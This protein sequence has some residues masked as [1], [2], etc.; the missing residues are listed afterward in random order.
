MN[1]AAI[2]RREATNLANNSTF[3]AGYHFVTTLDFLQHQPIGGASLF[4][5]SNCSDNQ[6]LSFGESLPI[7]GQKLWKQI[8]SAIILTDQHR[9]NTS[10]PGGKAL[11]DL[12]QI[13]WSTDE[14]WATD[15]AWAR[16]TA[17]SM[18]D[19]INSRVVKASEMPAFMARGPRA[20][21][22]RNEIKPAL[23]LELAKNHARITN[24][25]LFLWRSVDVEAGTQR[26]LSKAV[27]STL[28]RQQPENTADMPTYMAFFDGCY[29]VFEDSKFPDL[30]WVNNLC[31]VGKKICLD[32]RE[33]PDDMSQPYRLLHYPPVSI[34]VR[35]DGTTLGKLLDNVPEHCLPVSRR[36]KTFTVRAKP[37]SIPTHPSCQ[38]SPLC[39]FASSVAPWFCIMMEFKWGLPSKS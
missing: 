31:C 20:I 28:D 15:Q 9:F 27:L 3:M 22:L 12:V 21:V 38:K 10:T 25:R 19:I 24:K 39:R 5:L 6:L 4:S 7:Q 33:P 32:P 30:C 8:D 13:M 26:L 1:T 37:Q 11:W 18:L 16:S 2:V 34:C 35:P 29:Y 17:S 23:N 14:R 36:K